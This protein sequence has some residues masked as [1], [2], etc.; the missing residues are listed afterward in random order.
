MSAKNYYINRQHS[1]A[2]LSSSDENETMVV[3]NLDFELTC[4]MHIS[5]AD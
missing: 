4:S 1:T 2:L 3:N 5:H